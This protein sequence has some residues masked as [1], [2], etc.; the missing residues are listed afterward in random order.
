M[1]SRDVADGE[2]LARDVH[3]HGGELVDRDHLF[4]ADVER[5]G[6]RRAGQA[7]HAFEAFVDVEER[8]RLIAVAPDLDLAAQLGFGHLAA[9]GGGR[10]FLAAGPGAFGAED[11]VEARDAAFHA[12]VAAIGQ[13]QPL[14]EQFLPAVLAVGGGRIGGGFGAVG[15]VRVFL[16]VGRI[17]A[18]RGRIE[19]PLDVPAPAG[20]DHVQ[21]D[22]GRVVHDVGVVFAGED[23][24]RPAHVGGQL[25][26]LVEAAVGD[27]AADGLIAQIADE[28]IVGLG[29]GEF[30]KLEIDAANP[31]P[32]AL[33]ALDQMAADESRRRRRRVLISYPCP[34]S[35]ISE[36]FVGEEP[37]QPSA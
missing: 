34:P 5:A 17:H 2:L 24:A 36:R 31:E 20:L 28:E 21:I 9:D 37:R 19:H 12:V 7:Q 10:L 11:V 16:V 15:V 35:V 14:A 1:R 29:L 30:G 22:G 23:I 4:R 8:A 18:G 27:L 13:I 33:Q 6:V 32:L 25:I 3:D 26:D